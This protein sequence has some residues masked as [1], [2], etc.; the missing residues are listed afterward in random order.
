VNDDRLPLDLA[1]F[2]LEHH[3]C[4]DLDAE[5]VDESPTSYVVWMDCLR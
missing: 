3:R 5:V 4:G 2:Y 1:A